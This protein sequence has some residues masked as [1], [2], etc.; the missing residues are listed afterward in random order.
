MPVMDGISAAHEIR[1][2]GGKIS[3][4]PILALSAFLADTLS[5]SCSIAPFDATL[6][7][8]ANGNELQTAI[9]KVLYYR[10]A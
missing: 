8:P 7:K 3:R 2:L 6:A 9:Q 10:G 5:N 4:T 1:A